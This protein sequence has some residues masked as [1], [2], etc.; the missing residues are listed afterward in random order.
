MRSTD[1]RFIQKTFVAGLLL[2]TLSS[3]LSAQEMQTIEEVVIRAQRQNGMLDDLK[4]EYK[5]VD[6]KRIFEGPY[7]DSSFILAISQELKNRGEMK[8]IMARRIK[9][10]PEFPGSSLNQYQYPI[11]DEC[12]IEKFQ[13]F[14]GGEFLALGYEVALT[15]GKS[16]TLGSV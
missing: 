11:A 1:Y 16:H 13:L 3:P 9:M 10:P 6:G 4:R 7:G 5:S 14:D 15:D 2:S 8:R 12:G